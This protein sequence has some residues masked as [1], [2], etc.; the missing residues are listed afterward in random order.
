MSQAGILNVTSSTPAI[1]TNFVTDAGIA[2]PAANTLNILGGPG[3]ATSGAGNT[4][5]ISLTVPS[6][7]WL[8]V[9]SA[10]NPVLM[11]PDTGYIAKGVAP[12]NFVL[13]A[14]AA[15]GDI[16]YVEGYANLWTI[17]QNA[18]QQMFLGISQ[19]TTGVLGSLS[20]TVISDAVTLLC[21][22]ANNEFKIINS[23]GNITVI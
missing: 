12:V 11:V 10:D 23:V 3:I 18:G 5:T 6:V 20:A 19:T 7:P 17:A 1:P 15:I 22:T 4:V 2:V 13:P 16:I 8:V 14:A 9:T 21:V